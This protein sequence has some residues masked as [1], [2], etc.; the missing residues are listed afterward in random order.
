MMNLRP[1]E[2]KVGCKNSAG[3]S[4]DECGDVNKP[5]NFRRRPVRSSR[6]HCLSEGE[7]IRNSLRCFGWIPGKV[8]DLDPRYIA[9]PDPGS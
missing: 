1:V 9:K 3:P 8:K 4:G 6:S 7:A 2:Y 5:I